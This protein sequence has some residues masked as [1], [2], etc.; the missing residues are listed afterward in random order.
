ME[1]GY[2]KL[3]R[4]SFRNDLYFAEKFTRYQAWTDLLL[5]T[6][7]K[8]RTFMKRGVS[9]TLERGQVL[10][11]EKF[12]ADRWT[13]SRGK[14]RRFFDYLESETVQQIIQH[15]NNVCTYLTI[16]NY[17]AYQGDGTT[18]DTTND[19]TD[20][21]TNGTTDGTHQRREEGKE[22]KKKRKTRS[23]FIIPTEAEVREYCTERGNTID[24][25][26]FISFYTA[27]NWMIGKNK[28]VDWKAAI[29]TW[30]GRNKKD[31]PTNP[32]P[33]VYLQNSKG[34]KASKEFKTEA[35]MKKYLK[36]NNYH[37]DGKSGMWIQQQEEGKQ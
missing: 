12:L 6:N 20:G 7:Y 11:G 17:E 31:N 35:D 13:W 27:K 10:A 26:Q 23:K 24:P 9:I 36:K 15:K 19:T 1:Q 14:V 2:I 8:T 33:V 30:E 3:F 29:I 34:K 18:D 25:Q 16:L 4:S 32:L 5:L 37:K 22:E 21:T 28:M